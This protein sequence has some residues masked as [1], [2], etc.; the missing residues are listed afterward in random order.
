MGRDELRPLAEAALRAATGA[1]RVARMCPRCGSSAHG[2][3]RLLGSDL[4]ASLAYADGLALVA[5]GP[6]PVGIDVEEDGPPVE[7][8]GDRLAWTRTEALLKAT[9]RGLTRWPAGDALPDLP[10]RALDVP[11]H[12][13]TLAGAAEWA[14]VRASSE[15]VRDDPV[16]PPGRPG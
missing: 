15:V 5:W 14:V 4:A 10:T 16:V 1:S 11:G 12:V 3:P 2:R 13:A 6:G 7:G 9:G 8:V